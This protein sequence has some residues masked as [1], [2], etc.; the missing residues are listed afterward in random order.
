M[1]ERNLYVASVLEELAFLLEITGA[2]V[3]KIQAYKRAARTLRTLESPLEDVSQLDDIKGI[4]SGIKGIVST[5]LDGSLPQE[6]VDL[7][8]DIP[9][10]IFEIARLP[11]LG[12]KSLKTLLENDIIDTKTLEEKARSQTLREIPGFGEKTESRILEDLQR[13]K[14]QRN[15]YLGKDAWS[16]AKRLIERIYQ[17]KKED[18]LTIEVTG[19][20]RRFEPQ[21]SVVELIVKTSFDFEKKRLLDFL[22][23][24]KEETKD[25]FLY[26][27]PEGYLI[28]IHFAKENDFGSVYLRTTGTKEFVDSFGNTESF[29]EESEVFKENGFNFVP[30][31]LR[32]TPEAV[33]FLH[34]PLPEL[35]MLK[36]IKGDLHMHSNYSDGVTSILEMAKKAKSVG[37]VYIAISDHSKSLTV[38]NGLDD[39]RLLEQ[40]QEIDD[41]NQEREIGIWIF[42]AIEVDILKDGSLDLSN[43]TLERLDFVTA[44]VH[45]AFRMSK[46]EMTDR[47]IKAMENPYVHSIGHIT[48]RLLGRRPGY[49]LDWERIIK[50]AKKTHTA[51]ELNASPERLDIAEEF[52][53]AVIENNIKIV[54]NTDAHSPEGF[55]D[56]NF[57]VMTARRGLV[58]T[59]H[60]LNTLSLADFSSWLKEPRKS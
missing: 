36:D 45:S 7:R 44:S 16:F 3:F 54:I 15:L 2:N 39:K 53:G 21:V 31:E 25:G 37:Y 32:H 1:F 41:L 42:K 12:P 19:E 55:L 35:V 52:L 57:G 8:E 50:A 9:S 34:E 24:S 10:G 6:L 47:I 38:A 59:R 46:T 17:Y 56:M 27:S 4:G 28:K 11:G 23:L 51:L 49:E 26:K 58:E 29:A 43:Q 30:P 22:K 13:L 33:R 20:L 18:I 60:V 40:G 48:G 14:H 5:V